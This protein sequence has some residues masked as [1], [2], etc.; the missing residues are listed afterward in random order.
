[1]FSTKN[2]TL[3]YRA[4]RRLLV[5]YLLAA[6]LGFA[7]GVLLTEI[8]GVT[9]EKVVGFSTKRIAYV[10]PVLQSATELGMDLGIVLE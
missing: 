2:K 1:M 4:W 5:V 6:F 9:P 8:V 7:A 10:F 3:F